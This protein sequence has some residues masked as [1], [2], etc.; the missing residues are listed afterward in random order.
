MAFKHMVQFLP[1]ALKFVYRTLSMRTGTFFVVFKNDI[2]VLANWMLS[3][4]KYFW[5]MLSMSRTFFRILSMLK[6]FF[7]PSK[8]YT[9]RISAAFLKRKNFSSS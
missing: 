4:Q 9:W 3:M 1:H 8:K 2:F 6:H 5:R 7:S